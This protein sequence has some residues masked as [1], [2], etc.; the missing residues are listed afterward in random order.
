MPRV[1]ERDNYIFVSIVIKYNCIS[2]FHYA[3]S[4]ILNYDTPIL[5][6][7]VIWLPKASFIHNP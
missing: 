4:Y 3:R 5:H 7:H 2:Q 1:Q 6:Y